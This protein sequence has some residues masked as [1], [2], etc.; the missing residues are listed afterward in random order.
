MPDDKPKLSQLVQTKHVTVE[1]LDEL[2]SKYPNGLAVVQDDLKDRW[3][4]VL[5]TPTLNQYRQWKKNTFDPQKIVDANELIVDQ[6]CVFPD[7]KEVQRLMDKY[8]A[9][10]DACV[11]ALARLCSADG[12]RSQDAE[13]FDSSNGASEILAANPEGRAVT[14]RNADWTIIIRPPTRME[15]KMWKTNTRD[16]A[17]SWEATSILVSQTVVY[18]PQD[19]FQELL[20]KW[21]GIPEA[22]SGAIAELTSMGANSAGKS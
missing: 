13:T 2:E 22:C 19:K 3:A 8:P 5:K 6:C 11:D 20:A 17:H 7:R 18:P 14:G 10:P 1:K 9:M 4:L 15:F 16:Q 12:A 21:P